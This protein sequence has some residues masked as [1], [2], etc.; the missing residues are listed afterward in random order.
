MVAGN[1]TQY[2]IEHKR[3]EDIRTWK[4]QGWI[5]FFQA[6]GLW[7]ENRNIFKKSS[8]KGC[9]VHYPISEIENHN[10]ECIA[11]YTNKEPC[12]EGQSLWAGKIAGLITGDILVT[13]FWWIAWNLSQV[14][15]YLQKKSHSDKTVLDWLSLVRGEFIGE[16]KSWFSQE[17]RTL[18]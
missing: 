15:G 14:G 18:R 17:S 5:T 10:A 9:W 4:H 16:R 13:G 1:K 2:I 11:Y 12:S 3:R 6:Y 7:I 8:I